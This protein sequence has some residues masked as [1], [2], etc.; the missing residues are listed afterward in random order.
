MKGSPMSAKKEKGRRAG[1]EGTVWQE[2]L[3]RLLP[4]YGHRNWIVIA[5]AA[6]PKQS[7]R[8]IETVCTGQEPLAVLKRVL[9][10][11][12]GAPHVRAVVMLDAEL[13]YVA[14][15]DAPGAGTYRDTLK[16]LLKG[17]PVKVLPHREII[18]QLDQ[19]ARLFHVLL[20]KT[21]QAIPYTSVFLELDCGYWDD[22]KEARLRRAF[23]VKAKL[24]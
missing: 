7:A 17:Q 4:E 11:I 9:Q 21:E 3:R 15:K 20:L 18:D 2:R 24:A 1:R 10:E 8:G 12:A 13:D 16:T 23:G 6:Y 5:D 14:E 22:A 19:S